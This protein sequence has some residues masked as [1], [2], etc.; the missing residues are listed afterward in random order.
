MS[1][2]LRQLLRDPLVWSSML[3]L[4]LVLGMPG[5]RGVFATLFPELPRPL[6]EQDSF[7]SLTLAHLGLVLLAGSIASSLGL[8]G[9]IAGTRRWGWEFRP[10]LETLA[11]VGQTLPPVAVLAVAVPLVGFGALPALIA[12]A[13]YGLLPVLHATLAGLDSVPAAE[14]DAASGLGMTPAQILWRLE[15]PLAAPVILAGVRTS[16]VINIGTAAVAATVGAHNL[17]SPIIIGIN[18]YNTAYVLQGALV[19]GLLAITCDLALGRLAR[20]WAH[21]P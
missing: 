4:A 13:L 11:G 1:G 14:R 18:G 17:G 20:R 16:L 9:G 12:L 19:L 8:L 2:P 15:L 5:L 21:P 10:L 6:Y 7:L 3:L